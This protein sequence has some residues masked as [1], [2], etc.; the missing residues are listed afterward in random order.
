MNRPLFVR[1]VNKLSELRYFQPI[2]DTTGKPGFTGLQKCTA[3]IRMLAYGTAADATDEYLRMGASTAL[4]CLHKFVKA[5]ILFYEDDYLR[6]PTP[7][8]LKRLLKESER[9]G[10][11]GCIG[12]IDCMHWEWKNCLTAWK[13][14]YAR[15]HGKPTIV[16]EAVASYDLWIWHA[17][18]GPP[19]TLN[20]I[21]VLHRSLVFDDILQ[22][23]A[24]KV[25]F[26]VNGHH[27]KMAYYLTDGIYPEWS[28]FV[29]PIPQPQEPKAQLFDMLQ[30]AK[31]KEVER[32]FGVL[33]ARFAIVKN[34]ALSMDKEK[35]GNIMKACII[36]HN[37][38]VED[39][40]KA[41]TQRYETEFQPGGG[42]GSGSSSQTRVTDPA[43][44]PS[45][46]HN[47]MA[48][49]DD[50]RDKQKHHQ[51]KTD[52]VEHI[53]NKFGTHQPDAK[54][55]HVTFVNTV[56]N[57]NRLLRSRGPNALDGIPSFRF[58]AIPDGLPET[59]LDATQD[60][61]A[62]CESTMKNCLAPFKELLQRINAQDDVPPVSGIVSDG[63]MSFTLDAAEELG[64]PKVLLWTPSACGFMAYLHFHLFMEKGL[65]PFKGMC[66]NTLIER[67]QY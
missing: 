22:G 55:F 29:K 30:S 37:M 52:L 47:I 57:H 7:A 26:S 13:G 4:A 65:S 60:I 19:G 6:R 20:D 56:Y 51:L 32:A 23:H 16:L 43:H 1:I 15:G 39:E 46:V 59:D 42:D 45:N 5:I 53:W 24:P 66:S 63:V 33:Q 48:T 50:F 54:G 27:Y 17:F 18:F 9:R 12:S 49:R 35:I 14:Q 28:T 67:L 3:A 11:P 25:S 31:R 62:L 61:P 21:N 36:L 38:I 8:D 41:G 2:P 58:E 34:P 10:F 44:L 40:R 64:V